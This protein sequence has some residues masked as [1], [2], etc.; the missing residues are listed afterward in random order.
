VRRR[1]RGGARTAVALLAAVAVLG[2]CRSAGP[3]APDIPRGQL[4]DAARV[5]G[6]PLPPRVAALYRLQVPESSGLRASLLTADDAG[7][8]T[9]SDSFGRAVLLAAWSRDGEATLYD[10]DAGCA[11]SGAD[12]S[13]VVG[14]GG[15]PVEQ[16]VRLLAGRLPA[17]DGDVVRIGSGQLEV[18]GTTW[19]A[20]VTVAGD[21][22]RVLEVRSGTRAAEAWSITLG[23]HTGA[24]PK[25]IR[26]ERADGQWAR[27]ELI[28][29]QLTGLGPLPDLPDLPP[30]T[31][32]TAP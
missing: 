9:V 17:V 13:A 6:E 28:R 21:P 11:V 16:A 18:D 8:L 30:C 31:G 27:L 7:R 23:E 1:D 20:R 14:A 19:S 29:R 25:E 12:L 15:L 10:L 26:I 5:L 32:D 3:P 24:L 2:G 22:W 4:E